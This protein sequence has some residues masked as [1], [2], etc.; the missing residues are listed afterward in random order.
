MPYNGDGF[1]WDQ[2]R[3]NSI[4]QLVHDASKEM[5]LI[6]PLLKLYGP[7]GDYV[8]T[9]A[10]HQVNPGFP[11]PSERSVQPRQPLSVDVN[12]N[13]VP[14]KIWC[15]FQLR[16]EQFYDEDTAMSLAIEAAYRV[17]QAEDAVILRGGGAR[18]FLQSLN[19][20]ADIAQLESQQCLLR[21]RP[22][23][24]QR[25]PHEPN[26]PMP[27]Y[28]TES[29]LQGIRDLQRNGRYSRYAAIVGL[30]L[31]EE[32]M[33]PRGGRAFSA[34]IYELRVLLGENRFLHCP[35]LS[36]RSGVI[37]SLSGDAI[38]IAVP[39]DARVEVVEENRDVTLQV[40]EQIRLLVD[41][42]QAVRPLRTPRKITH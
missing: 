32:S 9:I 30:E 20:H 41:V 39:V 35:A 23:D 24:V 38:K 16:Q 12:Q 31:Y 6:R 28:I 27:N 5:R 17:A 2:G 14:V 13:V 15:E 25:P 11:A 3:W 22:P 37:F 21:D 29:I 34:E 33:R 40:V 7:Q 1:H 36:D 26:Q 4:N 10:G 18:A 8:R 42:P 19:V